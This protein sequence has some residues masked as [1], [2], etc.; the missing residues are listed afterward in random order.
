M[1]SGLARD[2]RTIPK[3]IILSRIG[4]VVIGAALSHTVQVTRFG[5]ILDQFCRRQPQVVGMDQAGEAV[6]ARVPAAT[7]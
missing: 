1:A 6:H 7:T 4:L 5:E 3:L 2:I